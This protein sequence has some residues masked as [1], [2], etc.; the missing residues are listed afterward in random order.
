LADGLVVGGVTYL[1]DPKLKEPPCEEIEEEDHKHHEHERPCELAKCNKLRC[2]EHE[3]CLRQGVC[4]VH[5]GCRKPK[6]C[7]ERP[8]ER[9]EKCDEEP[10]RIKFEIDLD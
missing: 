4:C 2:C 9:N 6:E 8:G 5:R 1:L 7:C 3:E 10:R